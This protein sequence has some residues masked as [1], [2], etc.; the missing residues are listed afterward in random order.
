[1]EQLL[2]KDKQSKLRELYDDT[3]FSDDFYGLSLNPGLT[4]QEIKEAQLFATMAHGVMLVTGRPGQGKDLFA[5]SFAYLIKRYFSN[6]KVFLDHKPKS[7]FGEYTPFTPDF[8]LREI[9]KMGQKADIDIE[10]DEEGNIQGSIEKQKKIAA[11]TEELIKNWLQ[12]GSEGQV[13]LQN[14]ILVLG[15]LKR[16]CYNRNPHNPLNKFIG[17]LCSIWRHLDLLIIGI[18][19]QMHEIDQYTFLYYVTHWADCSWSITRPFTTDVKIR[20]GQYLDPSRGVFG[21]ALKPIIFH[22]DGKKP[23]PFL[24]GKGFFDLYNSK[25]YTNLQPVLRRR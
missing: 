23:R 17:G 19:P 13:M 14:G 21:V 7:L 3:E 22:V 1:M 18:T 2:E 20:R 10:T 24:G 25:N 5:H 6:R 11:R 8:L 9:K 12:D 16:W 4:E 15:E